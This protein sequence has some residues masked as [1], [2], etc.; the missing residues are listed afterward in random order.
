MRA[1]QKDLDALLVVRAHINESMPES[2]SLALE[3]SKQ[4][5]GVAPWLFVSQNWKLLQQNATER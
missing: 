5:Q 4:R 2:F 1:A 3:L